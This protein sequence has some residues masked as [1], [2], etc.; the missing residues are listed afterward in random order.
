[1]ATLYAKTEA[2]GYAEFYP[3]TLATEV[4][5]TDETNK[6]EGETV[7]ANI[8]NIYKILA[9]LKGDDEAVSTISIQVYY[10]ASSTSDVSSIKSNESL[11]LI[12]FVTTY[13]AATA[14]RPYTWK[15]TVISAGTS[16][17]TTYEICATYTGLLSQTIY[18]ATNNSDQVKIE[19]E[20]NEDGTEDLTCFDNKLPSD[21]QEIPQS[22]SQV[23]PYA[24]IS[25]RNKVDG[26]WQKFST[27][28]LY[29]KWNFN[30]RVLFKYALTEDTSTPS[31]NRTS[32]NPGSDWVDSYNTPS[33][34]YI[35]IWTITAS[36]AGSDW[37]TDDSSNI[38]SAPNLTGVFIKSE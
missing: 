12:Q 27:P 5:I 34:D 21:W 24:Y 36:K 1:M 17:S 6:T 7:E 4:L 15:K 8:S 23:T 2:G 3:T 16:T 9:G 30:T 20:L 33:G 38:W 28:A 10:H 11:E 32:D 18:L 14:D 29:G 31:C 22:I 26:K 19:Y 25:V 35:Y 37:V 13:Q